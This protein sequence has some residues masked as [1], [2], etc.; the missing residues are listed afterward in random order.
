MKLTIRTITKDRTSV[1]LGANVLSIFSK[2]LKRREFSGTKLFI[3]VD[4]HT[5]EHCLPVL[6]KALPELKS[7]EVL[8]ID[9]GEGCKSIATAEMLWQKL[10]DAGADRQSVIINLGGGVVSDLGGFVAGGFQRGIRYFNVPT[11]LIGQ[12]DAAIGGKTGVNLGAIKNQ[13]GLFY[14]PEGIFIVPEFLNTLPKNHLRSGLGEIIKSILLSDPV[15]WQKIRRKPKGTLLGEMPDG[16]MWQKLVFKAAAY[17]IALV[18]ADYR[19]KKSRKSLNF[20]HTVGHALES[21]T[22]A[23]GLPVLLH[24]DAVVAGMICAAWLSY[25]K[26]DLNKEHFEEISSYLFSEFEPVRFKESD[27]PQIVNLMKFDKKNQSGQFRFT[28]LAKPGLPKINVACDSAEVSESLVNY[29][30]I[31]ERMEL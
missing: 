14:S 11:S 30:K 3:L 21:F 6:I 4:R 19:E 25:K 9:G 5:S 16:P 27:I 18:T 13:I 1:Y 10:H 8:K 23:N 22:I 2:Q 17:K 15:Q 28:L 7:A 31:K 20:G 26:T 24:G 29:L 12:A